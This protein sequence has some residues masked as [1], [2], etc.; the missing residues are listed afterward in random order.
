MFKKLFSSKTSKIYTL[1]IGVAVIVCLILVLATAFASDTN[2]LVYGENQDGTYTVKDIK[3]LYRGGLFHK[4]TLVI[5]A[6]Y[7]GEK[8][9]SIEKVESDHII[10]IIIEEGIEEIKTGAFTGMESLVKITIPESVKVIGGN[11][12]SNCYSLKDITFPNHITSIQSQTFKGCKSLETFTVP[13]SVDYIGEN[14]FVECTSLKEVIL[15]SGVE[16]IGNQ[17]FKGCT[18]LSKLS[19]PTTVNHIGESAFEGCSSLETLQISEGLPKIDKFAF[20]GM[21]GLKEINIPSTVTEIAEGAFMNC[22]SLTNVTLPQGIAKIENST[23]ENCTNLV[24]VSVPTTVTFV[25]ERAF[26]NCSSLTSLSLEY[27]TEVGNEAFKGSTKLQTI[28]FEFANA[29]VGYNVFDETA[30]AKEV[31]KANKGLLIVGNV[32]YDFDA[33]IYK[34]ENNISG[35]IEKLIIPNGIEKINNG[36]FYDSVDFSA[37]VL[38]ETLKL[39]GAEAFLLSTKASDSLTKLNTIFFAGNDLVIEEKAFNGCKDL[40][41]KVFTTEDAVSKVSFGDNN[42]VLEKAKNVFVEGEEYYTYVYLTKEDS[43]NKVE[44]KLSY[45]LVKLQAYKVENGSKKYFNERTYKFE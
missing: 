39:I 17:A 19:I 14:A 28:N 22:T 30:F 3:S 42:N 12:F 11:S 43:Q 15:S 24:S 41:A 38:P 40:K 21:S 7:K 37:I 9:V 35:N 27:V 2:R 26:A 33:E 13:S 31:I 34:Q 44:S 29:K 6:T 8:V 32:V 5:P 16:S 4:K 18:N 23:F 1:I 20:A 25:G 45:D 10:E 36:A